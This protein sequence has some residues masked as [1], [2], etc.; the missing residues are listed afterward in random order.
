MIRVF[1][2]ELKTSARGTILFIGVHT[3]R[4]FMVGVA[5]EGHEEQ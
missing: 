1:L 4:F 5:T 2:F 3:Y